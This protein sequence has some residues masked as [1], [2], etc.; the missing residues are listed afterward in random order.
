MDERMTMIKEILL[1][2]ISTQVGDIYNVDCK[3]LG[4]A[5]DMI[6]DLEEACYYH[7]IPEAMKKT[8]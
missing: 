3:E 2:H 8:E 7:T 1:S 4:E 5:I 6:K